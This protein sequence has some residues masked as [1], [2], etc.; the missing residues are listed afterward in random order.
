MKNLCLKFLGLAML[1]T[2]PAH[3]QKTI[4][5]PLRPWET[6][7]TWN[8]EHRACPTPYSDSKKHLC[9]WPS[10][11]G[12]QVKKDGAQF[13]MAVTVF[14][15]TWLPL[16]GA[17]DTWPLEVRANGAALAVL[18]HDGNP[19]VRLAAGTVRVE[20]H[21]AGTK[22]RTSGS[23]ARSILD[24]IDGQPVEAPVWDAKL[25]GKR[26]GSAERPTKISFR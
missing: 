3:A 24:V 2:I 13:D 6:W 18:E 16:P 10:R 8:D 14:H 12:L 1:A 5:E 17:A 11:L 19:A 21:I 26:D 25:S 22:S 23:R 15:E 4:P 20:G 9:F 7:A